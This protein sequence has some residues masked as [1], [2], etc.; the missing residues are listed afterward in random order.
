M[1]KILFPFIISV[2]LFGCTPRS[3]DTWEATDF[4]YVGEYSLGLEG[5]AVDAEGNL[6]FVNPHKN[7]TIGKLSPDGQLELYIDSLPHGSVAN[8]IRFGHDGL[9]YLADYV[10]HNILTIDPMHHEVVVFAH[11]STMNQPNDIAIS[12]KGMLYASDPNWANNTGNLWRVNLNGKFVQL[13]DSMGTT[14]GV[15]VA[16]GDSLLYVNES[17][18]RKIWVFDLSPEGDISNKRL[19]IE[20]PDYGLDGM[21]CDLEGS[22]YVA[23]YEKG[24][25]AIISPAGEL[26]Q[27]VKL[28]G[29]KPT[30]IAF[31][32]SDGQTCYVTC[33]DRGYIETFRAPYPGRSW[34]LRQ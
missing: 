28:T 21:R 19:L 34:A 9:M 1:R 3:S 6:F 5:P 20:F 13:A 25:I 26:L 7:G 31:G 4:A 22:L 30:N 33:Q 12:E 24:V 8:G 17:V 32:G 23:R 16:P 29:Q 27:E 18:Q 2:V 14:N 15:E 10:N 11:D